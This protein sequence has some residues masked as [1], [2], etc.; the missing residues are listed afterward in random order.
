MANGLGIEFEVQ[1]GNHVDIIA[2]QGK[3]ISI[4]FIFGGENPIDVT[5]Y[6]AKLHIREEFSSS[7]SVAEFTTANGRVT[8]GSS[9]GLITFAMSA[10][11]SASLPSELNGVYEAEIISDTGVVYAGL[12][13]KFRVRPEVV[14]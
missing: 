3:T 9:D 5:G 1:G 13:G 10:T 2:Y 11:D 8:I 7:T 12:Y 4:P 14:R 6:D